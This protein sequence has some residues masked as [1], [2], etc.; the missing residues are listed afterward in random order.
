MKF[1][2]HFFTL[3]LLTSTYTQA[4][5]RTLSEREIAARN[6]L[7]RTTGITN[8][9]TPISQLRLL[10]ERSDVSIYGLETG[11]WTVISHDNRLPAV[12]AYGDDK[13]ERAI[14][15][16][17]FNHFLST[18]S[19]YLSHC[20]E[21]STSPRLL[22][23][24]AT[25]NPE[26]V[27]EIMKCRW[28]QGTPY[29][30]MCP[31]VYKENSSKQLTDQRC[32]TGCVATA[33]A[34]VMYTL[35]QQQGADIRLRGG[36]YYYYINDSKRLAF[37]KSYLGS[38]TLDWDNMCNTYSSTSTYPQR[39]AV[40]RLMYACG[41]A[42]EMY[43]STGASGTYTANAAQGINEYFQGINCQYTGYDLASYE[44][45]I[46]D[47]FD[48]GRPIILS[49]T[50][51]DG[52]HCFV[53]DGYDKE[54]RI[55]LNLGWSGGGNTWTFI[56]ELGGFTG[57]QTAC[58]VLPTKDDQLHLSAN[59]PL[60]E[61]QNQ[62]LTAD[63]HH[64]ASTITPNQWYVLYNKGQYSSTYSTGH[65]KA[66]R[67][68]HYTPV[69]DPAE[70]A[71]PMIV[72]FISKGKDTYYIQTGTGDYFGGQGSFT[73]TTDNQYTYTASQMFP[74]KA[75]H[76]WA[77]R[78]DGTILSCTAPGDKG[79]TSGGTNLM[80]DSLGHNCWLLLPVTLA[81]TPDMPTLLPDRFDPTHSYS[82]INYDQDKQLYLNVKLTTTLASS[83]ADYH[84]TPYKGGWSITGA[85]D[86]NI[87]MSAK[88]RDFKFG[89]GLVQNDTPLPFTF[90][91]CPDTFTTG[92]K[93]IDACATLYRIHCESGYL[94]P[95]KNNSGAIVYG[96][97]GPHAQYGRW[98]VIDMT[99]LAQLRPDAISPINA[100]PHTTHQD[101]E[102]TTFELSGRPIGHDA[103]NHKHTIQINNRSK[104][105]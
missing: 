74:E 16:P 18:F 56:P 92:D 44:Q 57:A 22:G 25:F 94:A 40:A 77:F 97:Q 85:Y 60:P 5:E 12:L 1:R 49:G 68:M 39:M 101:I 8:L 59:Q 82:I 98:L 87:I 23:Q 20:R 64:P 70:I 43:Y 35:H 50:S 17:N 52:S 10:A 32:I 27:K 102:S 9:S 48:A 105:F 21:T 96:N 58:F 7:T 72:R 30:D 67:N 76:Y 55:H 24:R 45:R 100:Q 90:E 19:Q 28:D 31:F 13:Y 88:Q 75:P 11:G 26:G 46:Y 69:C 38:L 78:Q 6:I 104:H 91:P 61:L 84:I 3:L 73:T 79:L 36:K 37:E 29:N 4:I 41:V 51:K 63:L 93:Q 62:Y 42:S 53:G 54:G 83:R 71:A 81:S 99:K 47:E 89:N 66:V 2:Y 33:M 80:P 65:G 103:N 14:E 95:Q 34:M 15:N 86:P